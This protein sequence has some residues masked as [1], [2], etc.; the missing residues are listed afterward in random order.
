MEKTMINKYKPA[1]IIGPGSTIRREM[2]FRGWTQD[3]LAEILGVSAKSINL[4]INNK[5]QITVDT[6]QK[7]SKAFGQSAE[8]WINRDT[9]YR[10]RL[11]EKQ[12]NSS[13]QL[14]A[15][16]ATAYQYMPIRE[17][18]KKGWWEKCDDPVA[19]VRMTKAF[20]E[21]TELDF[22]FLDQ[23]ALPNF[24]KSGA[25]QQYNVYHALTWF[26]MAKRCARYYPLSSSYDANRLR[27]LADNLS[28][29]SLKEN[30]PEHFL[31]DLN[32]AGVKF[33]VLSHLPKTYVDGASF[34]D[35]E[36]PVIVYTQ[37]HNR[38]DN[39]WF[40]VAHEIGHILLHLKDKDTFFIDSEKEVKTEQEQEADQFAAE[41]LKVPKILSEFA[42][43][44]YIKTDLVLN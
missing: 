39:F 4:L 19:L 5:Q 30:G 26:Q 12:N 36:H 23:T 11:A 21:I 29:Y 42:N 3:D 1:R 44:R 41:K 20:W 35:D 24:R 18:I 27:D 22:S 10:L 33:F 34:I 16:K 6:A 43:Q 8:Y 15:A 14:V 37:R 40:T 31:N 9:I 28:R 38:Y 7:F 13:Q 2:E 25:F 32:A 17:M